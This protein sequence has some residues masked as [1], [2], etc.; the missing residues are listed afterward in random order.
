MTQ[1]SLMSMERGPPPNPQSSAVVA[2]PVNELPHRAPS[3]VV[4][5]KATVGKV[6]ETAATA[7]VAK[8]TRITL[9]LMTAL[10]ARQALGHPCDALCRPAR[11]R[12]VVVGHNE[13]VVERKM[14][15]TGYTLTAGAWAASLRRVNPDQLE[16]ASEVGPHSGSTRPSSQHRLRPRRAS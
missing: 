11:L 9:S 12:L 13:T 6:V 14:T 7:K 1:K 8:V 3:L 4:D 15:R 10:I 16:H 2:L 5:P